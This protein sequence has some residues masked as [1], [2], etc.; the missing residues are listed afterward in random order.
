M[1]ITQIVA[2]GSFT[3][4]QLTLLSL[5]GRTAGGGQMVGSGTIGFADLS[6]NHGPTLDL[7]I[8]AQ[9]AQLMARPDMALTATGPLR[10]ISDGSSGTIAGRL[11]IDNARWALGKS[12]GL[13][14]LPNIPT[15][16]INRSAD[17]APA[18][19]AMMPWNFLVDAAPGGRIRVEGLGINSNWSADIQLRG[20]LDAPVM[21]GTA[22]L[23][24]GTYDFA[25]RRFD[26]TRGHLAFTGTSPPDPHLDIAATATVTGLTATVTV[27]GTSLRPNIAFSSVPALPEEDLLARVLFGDSITSISAPEALELGSALAGLH[28]GG[29]LDPIN[30]LRRAIGLDRLRIVNA[31]VTIPRQTGFGAGKYLGRRVYAEI[32]TDGRGYSATN[33]EFRIT[34]WLSLL[35]SI[36]TV[37]RQNINAKISKDY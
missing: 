36:S 27:T 25:G 16:E 26:M 18:S 33:L 4:S 20:T 22:D 31:D 7:R 1:D 21:A 10:I 14:E 13:T 6:T 8:G 37:N 9:K 12:Q 19:A 35:G 23:I 34:R 15:R 3:G 24:D 29:G 11:R 28:G 5:A 2:R 32:I 17:I 30:K